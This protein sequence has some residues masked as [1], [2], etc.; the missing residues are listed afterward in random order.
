M[1]EQERAAIR[2]EVEAKL[3]REAE[4]RAEVEAKLQKEYEEKKRQLLEDSK[5]KEEEEKL[6]LEEEKRKADEWNALL[7]AAGSGDIQS[8]KKLFDIYSSGTASVKKDMDSAIKWLIAMA[9]AGDEASQCDIADRYANGLDVKQDYVRAFHYYSLSAKQGNLNSKKLLGCWYLLGRGVERDY[10][11]A[12][13]IFDEIFDEF[14]NDDLTKKAYADALLNY[15]KELECAKATLHSEVYSMYEKSANLGNIEAK[16]YLGHCYQYGISVN[17]DYCQAYKFYRNAQR[18]GYSSDMLHGWINELINSVKLSAESGEPTAQRLMAK[19]YLKGSLLEK[20]K[21]KAIEWLQKAAGQGDCDA[22]NML[23]H[24]FE[25]KGNY[26]EAF[27]WFK[28]SAL[29]NIDSMT[30]LVQFYEKGICIK[31]DNV[32]EYNWY[33]KSKSNH[34]TLSTCDIK[35][36]SEIIRVAEEILNKKVQ[37]NKSLFIKGIS[38]F[39][40]D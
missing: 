29:G 15:G 24:Y 11:M 4:I 8:Q 27:C 28:K 23:G 25:D 26:G 5:R 2:A 17:V 12:I 1:D 22:Q 34:V 35:D 36:N 40:N 39:M 19:W 13:Q 10:K 37:S 6:K 14:S 20:N 16:A 9:D 33:M 30:C 3:K 32:M 31:K 18:H 7:S 21:D 38:V